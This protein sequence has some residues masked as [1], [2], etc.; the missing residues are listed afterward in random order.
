MARQTKPKRPNLI[1]LADTSAALLKAVGGGW[2]WQTAVDDVA[3][4]AG[5]TASERAE[6]E[7][8]LAARGCPP[9]D[10]G[11]DDKPSQPDPGDEGPYYDRDKALDEPG[12]DEA[13]PTTE[14]TIPP[15]E[16]GY[17]RPAEPDDDSDLDA[18]AFD[19][20]ARA[21]THAAGIGHD[22]VGEPDD[23]VGQIVGPDG[24][25]TVDVPR[26]AAEA[27]PELAAGLDASRLQRIADQAGD[28]EP[29]TI[30]RP[31]SER[32]TTR[33]LLAE[34][35]D[36][37]RRLRVRLLNEGARERLDD[38]R[39]LSSEAMRSL[40]ALHPLRKTL[41]PAVFDQV[42]ATIVAEIEREWG[43]I[44]T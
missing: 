25:Q 7:Q 15:G 12:D 9:P 35:E 24:E 23:V 41:R 34:A 11:E 30:G 1:K 32:R 31:G 5:L 19:A 20:A 8:L 43:P 26:W 21:P 33:E 29:S 18:D 16:V 10:P 17:T 28:D 42:M 39:P 2:T 13:P 3:G 44:V 36:T 6:L 38:A 14:T 27:S 37:A 22:P 40:E 4:N